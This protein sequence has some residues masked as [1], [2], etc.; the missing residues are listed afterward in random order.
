MFAFRTS[1]NELIMLKIA[2][3][4]QDLAISSQFGA[5]GCNMGQFQCL[6]ARF[7]PHQRHMCYG[8]IALPSPSHLVFFG[9]S[10]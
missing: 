3:L 1:E 4:S 5:G 6:E 2:H 10:W 8:S 7:A 9:V